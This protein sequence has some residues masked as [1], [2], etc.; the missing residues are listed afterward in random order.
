[1]ADKPLIIAI[2]GPAA[3]GKGT[4][5]RALADRLDFAHLDTGSLYRAVGVGVLEAGGDPANEEDA[6]KAAK[7]LK[8]NITEKILQNPALRTHEAGS[9]AS[10]VAQY[11]SVR[12]VLR[13]LQTG[14][15]QNPPN[16]KAGAVLD[17]RDIGTVICPDAPVKLFI[18]ASIEARADRR[19]KELQNKGEAATYGAVL[20]EM[21]A[22]DARDSDRSVSPLRPADDAFILDTSDL[23]AEAAFEQALAYIES[24]ISI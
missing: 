18:T 13:E 22:R 19:F 20:E 16:G 6:V 24:K 1:M 17:G 5:A 8:A 7:T 12:A 4:L 11:D 14:F 3:A 23:D 2:D 9:A 15:A 10:K 21:R